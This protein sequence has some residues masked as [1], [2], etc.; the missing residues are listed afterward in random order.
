[1]KIIAHTILGERPAAGD[2][3]P[4]AAARQLFAPPPP[5]LPHGEELG[6]APIPGLEEEEEPAGGA[7]GAPPAAIVGDRVAAKP[8]SRPAVGLHLADQDDFPVI[9]PSAA[10]TTAFWPFSVPAPPASTHFTPRPPVLRAE[11][12]RGGEST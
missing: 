2:Q 12:I 5:P 11:T 10:P 8:S 1:M 6:S 3:E 9:Q 4:V 7:R